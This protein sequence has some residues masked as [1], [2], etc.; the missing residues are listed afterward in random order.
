M[1]K[2]SDSTSTANAQ[3]EFTEG[4][5][6]AGVDATLLKASW[7][8]AIQRELVSVIE[9]GGT[10]P[11]PADDSQLLKSILELK[12]SG[13][14]AYARDT[15]SI[16]AYKA[17]YSPP[18]TA[19]NDGMVI[20]FR[21][22]ITNSTASTITVDEL[23]SA[24]IV[25]SGH[26][27]LQGNEITIDA[28]VWLQ[29][30]SSIGSGAWVLV[31][32]AGAALSVAPAT[33]SRHVVT[34][35]QLQ[36][37]LRGSRKF[38]TSGTF[39]VPDN[40]TRLYISGC[41]G[42]GGGGGGAGNKTEGAAGSCGGGGGAGE[43]VEEEAV[44]VTPGQVIQIV[45]GAEGCGGGAGTPDGKSATPGS[46]GGDTIVGDLVTLT[47]GKGGEQGQNPGASGAAGGLGGEGFPRGGSGSD[48]SANVNNAG[49]PGASGAGGT[50]CFGGGGPC[51]RCGIPTLGSP[52]FEGISASGCG[53]GGGGGAASYTG[54]GPG[55]TGGS[56]SPGFVRIGW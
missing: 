51:Q 43:F 28:D 37:Q 45:I 42:G 55:G 19:V 50:G 22:A 32:N 34:L 38:V 12:R 52:I 39:T 23:P 33:K 48:G 40:V 27:P 17:T 36:D 46:N 30:N 20:R 31:G 6:S 13:S 53:S 21:A 25:G 1:Q 44:A 35:G 10:Q 41:A 5:P 54:I 8:N 56:G 47:G 18:I 16:N 15:G 14:G 9:A 24:P 11:N 4:S 49:W 3:G 29:W 2:I 7:L 26:L